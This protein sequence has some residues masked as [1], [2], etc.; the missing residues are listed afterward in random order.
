MQLSAREIPQSV[1]DYSLTGDLLSFLRCQR[2]YRFQNGSALPPARPIQ[3]W[4]GEFV[5]GCMEIA[6]D[7]WKVKPYSFPWPCN[8]VE[9]KDRELATTL[10]ENDIGEMGRKIERM[11][12][13]QGKTARNRHARESAYA[14]VEA[15]INLIGPH[16]FPLVT[17]AEEPLAGTRAIPLE[18]TDNLR[19]ARYGL[20]GVVDVLSAIRL[21]TVTPDNV[22][23]LAIERELAK[24]P[25]KLPSDYEVIVDYKGSERPNPIDGYWQQHEWQIQTYAWLR[26]RKT[27]ALPIVAGI[28]LYVNELQ[29]TE[30]QMEQLVRLFRKKELDPMPQAG[31]QDFNALN[32]WAPGVVGGQQLT[33]QFRIARALRVV[34]VTDASIQVALLEFDRVVL[35]IER[36]VTREVNA[37]DITSAWAPTCADEQTC[38]ACD[39]RPSCPKPAGADVGYTIKAPLAP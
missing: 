6:L 15:T 29:P 25:V 31:S 18:A 23:R 16:L 11:L 39:F 32:L 34:P 37:A 30:G 8:M 33:A 10:P 36:N 3:L 24:H 27:D 38:V 12:A 26:Q 20:T 14:R 13:T 7:I 35:D 19:A 5:H 2:Q 1:P 9:W 28:V 22:I 4:F 21:S 17:Y